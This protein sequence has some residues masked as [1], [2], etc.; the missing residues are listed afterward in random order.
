MSNKNTFYN[1][2]TPTK[3][4]IHCLICESNDRLNWIPTIKGFENRRKNLWKELPVEPYLKIFCGTCAIRRT[5]VFHSN[6][7]LDSIE[8]AKKRRAHENPWK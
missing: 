7:S 2:L 5:Q 1:W 8:N 4:C 6:Q 3:N